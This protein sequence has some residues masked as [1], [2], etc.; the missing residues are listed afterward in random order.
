MQHLY[1]LRADPKLSNQQKETE[2]EDAATHCSGQQ[3]MYAC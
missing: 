3:E 2:I 1:E